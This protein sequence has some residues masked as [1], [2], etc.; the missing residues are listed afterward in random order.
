MLSAWS[1]NVSAS[2]K[3][4]GKIILAVGEVVAVSTS[5]EERKLKR[6]S[7]IFSGDTLTTKDGAR[8]QVRFSDKSLVAL[9]ESSVF[10]VDEYSFNQSGNTQEK[11]IYS[12]LKGGMRTISGAIGKNNR[13][14][15]KLNT[16]VATIGIRGTAFNIGLITEDGIQSL[17]GTVDSGAIIIE[18]IKEICKFKLDKI[19]RFHIIKLQG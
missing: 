12:L 2:T 3:P 5:G 9:P 1:F 15:Y 16:P 19:S 7:K 4:I 13:D 11:A 6:R 8:C 10:K 14:D 17:Y 18:M